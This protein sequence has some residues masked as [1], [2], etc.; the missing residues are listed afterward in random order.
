MPTAQEC[1]A[2]LLETVPFTMRVLA[3]AMHQA[4]A[5]DSPPFNM[6]QLRM[7]DM[8]RSG[9]W[10]LSDL[11]ERHQVATSTM[12]RTVDVLVKRTWV[13]R[14]SHPDDRRQVLLSLTG[15]GLEVLAE[16]RRGAEASLTQLVEQ[17]PDDER[18]RLFAGLQVLQKLGL[19]AVEQG[20]LCAHRPPAAPG[21]ADIQKET[22]E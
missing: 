17:L 19:R 8:L 4:R 7:L 14:R 3:G 18:E 2:L 6:G 13:E 10:T 22:R 16:M 12:S 21:T 15:E 1:A 11:A 9:A 5:S 20:H